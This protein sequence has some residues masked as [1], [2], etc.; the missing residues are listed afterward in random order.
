MAVDGAAPTD[1]RSRLADWLEVLTLSNPRK[2]AACADLIGQ[3]D[4]LGDAGHATETEPETGQELDGEILEDG[5]R[6]FIDAVLEELR[7]RADVL[8]GRYPF[9]IDAKGPD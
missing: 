6:A 8:E 5:R 7:Y 9:R 4:L 3:H 1:T 2:V